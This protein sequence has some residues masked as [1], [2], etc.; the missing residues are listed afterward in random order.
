MY[1]QHSYES[2]SLGGY[3]INI[4]IINKAAL[5]LVNKYISSPITNN[6][7]RR[8]RNNK[9]FKRLINNSKKMLFSKLEIDNKT[10]NISIT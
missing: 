1:N 9:S 8:P 7:S 2:G 10:Q 4:S 6:I 5:I 3:L